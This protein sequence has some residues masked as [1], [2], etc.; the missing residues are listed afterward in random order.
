MDTLPALTEHPKTHPPPRHRLKPNES[1]S[2]PQWI[3]WPGSLSILLPSR[4]AMLHV[5]KDSKKARQQRKEE[6][7]VTGKGGCEPFDSAL[8]WVYKAC[9]SKCQ[10]GPTAL[11]HPP[12]QYAKK[13]GD[14]NSCSNLLVVSVHALQLC[15]GT[16]YSICNQTETSVTRG[17]GRN[18]SPSR[19]LSPSQA[20][21]PVV[22][23]IV[24]RNL[25]TRR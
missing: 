14:D 12:Q 19:V 13:E 25:T 16:H 24:K 23:P 15:T 11:N 9:A 8:A 21:L 3:S 2:H 7:R 5:T 1:Q 4:S 22:L 20:P 17:S 10:L 6:E 18:T